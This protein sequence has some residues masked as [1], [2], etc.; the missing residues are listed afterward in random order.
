M[1][2]NPKNIV[3]VN[4]F[5]YLVSCVVLE[6]ELRKLREET[7]IET[8]KQD[9]ERERLKR[10]ELE[11]KLSD[12]LKPR[13][14]CQQC[15]NSVC[16]GC[17]VRK[18]YHSVL[19]IKLNNTGF[20]GGMNEQKCKSFQFVPLFD[21]ASIFWPLEFVKKLLFLLFVGHRVEDSPPQAP[22]AQP[23]A[24]NGTGQ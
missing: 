4:R 12:V 24:V 17:Q 15:K 21:C 2:W 22:K 10:L 6:E 3:T 8:L 16:C 23:P 13:Y 9:L 19:A 18:M 1:C 5:K 20:A 11:Q 7:N 14:A